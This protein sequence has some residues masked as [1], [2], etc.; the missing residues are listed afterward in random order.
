V[1]AALF[2][3]VVSVVSGGIGTIVVVAAIAWRWPAIRRL[4]RL[5]E[6]G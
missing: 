2:T 5:S 6:P 3:P 1:V 4:G